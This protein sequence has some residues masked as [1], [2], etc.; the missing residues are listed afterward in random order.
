MRIGWGRVGPRELLLLLITCCVSAA[1][2]SHSPLSGERP[3]RSEAHD[4]LSSVTWSLRPV[5]CLPNHSRNDHD[6]LRVL[7]SAHDT[8][9][10]EEAIRPVSLVTGTLEAK[11]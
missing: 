7:L 4:Q 9:P 3:T 11:S 5:R 1:S 10:T 2:C 6:R 8:G